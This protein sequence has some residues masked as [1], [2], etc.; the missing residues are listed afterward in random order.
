MIWLGVLWLVLSLVLLLW[1]LFR[2]N[3][4]ITT[5]VMIVASNLFAQFAY[6]EMG[7]R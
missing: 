7:W 3:I 2:D 6:I 4:R 1:A 5:F